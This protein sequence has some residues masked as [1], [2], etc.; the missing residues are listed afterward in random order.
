[1][2][3]TSIHTINSSKGL[4]FFS[5]ISWLLF[6]YIN[7]ALPSF[8]RTRFITRNFVPDVSDEVWLRT[9][10]DSSPSRKLCDLFWLQLPWD[11]IRSELGCINVFDTGCGSGHYGPRLQSY[12]GGLISRYTGVDI[13]PH[14]KWKRLV[15]EHPYLQFR[16]FDGFGISSQ[17]PEDANLF[18]SQS[19]VEHFRH[20][21]HYFTQLRDFITNRPKPAIQIHMFPSTACIRLFLFHGIRQYSPRTVGYVVNLFDTESYSILYNLGGAACNRLHRE[22]ITGPVKYKKVK[23]LRAERIKE[24]DMR[25]RRAIVAD[26]SMLQKESSFYALVI[27]SNWK[28][29]TFL[30]D[31]SSL[32]LHPFRR[33]IE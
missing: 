17:I 12:S 31:P 6:N 26:S 9:D 7:N 4:N 32:N 11:R 25:L 3:S 33:K 8:T 14:S 22:Y 27:H 15:K 19:A 28:E 10:I 5:R 20:D 13:S 30:H 24:Y 1:M 18:I 29:R 23:D 21:L 16:K 2:N